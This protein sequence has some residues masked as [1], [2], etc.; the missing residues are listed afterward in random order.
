M[1]TGSSVTDSNEIETEK[2]E[3]TQNNNAKVWS[4]ILKIYFMFIYI[5]HR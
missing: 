3:Y 5:S 2:E 1:G 4:F